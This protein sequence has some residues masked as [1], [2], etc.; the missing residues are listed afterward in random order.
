M[1]LNVQALIE[2]RQRIINE[3]RAAVES[4][5][6]EKFDSLDAQEKLLRERIEAAQRVSALQAEAEA[7]VANSSSSGAAVASSLNYWDAFRR[8]IT[9]PSSLSIEERALLTNPPGSPEYRTLST[10]PGSAGG[11]V[12]PPEFL[13]ELVQSLKF[14]ADFLPVSRVIT[15]ESGAPLSVPKTDNTALKAAIVGENAAV[16]LTT[17]AF[18]SISIPVY[19]F[20]AQLRASVEMLQ[21]AFFDVEGYMRE[22]LAEMFG[23]ALSE[24]LTK[25]SGV[26]EPSGIVTGA[27]LGT[28]TATA[29]TISRAKILDLIH[30]LDPAYRRMPNTRFMLSDA[31]LSAIKKLSIG[32]SDDRPLWQPSM[33]EGEPD[34][35]E[36]FPYI[37]NNDMDSLGT[38][39]KRIMVFGDFSRFY[40]RQV[41]P[42]TYQ[43]L[44]EL[45]AV[46]GQVGIVAY[47]RWGS[48]VVN[49]DAIKF[50][51]TP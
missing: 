9:S 8:M 51:K 29:T 26:N 28:T 35:I 19:K 46:N 25:G 34:R 2:E 16:A 48:A 17:L 12:V 18:D 5:D 3:M 21:D 14:Y 42:I 44:V 32:S 45:F 36:G 6:S 4:G 24:K 43:P 41:L 10:S 47:A 31:T 11:Y 27:S 15:T 13:R 23:R 39:D 33:R 7:W 40:V 49:S 30:S 20:A 37:V 50:M 38:A 22:V 1:G